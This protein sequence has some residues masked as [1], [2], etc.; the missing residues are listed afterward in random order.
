MRGRVLCVIIAAM[1]LLPLASASASPPVWVAVNGAYTV[2]MGNEHIMVVASDGTLWAWGGN[3]FGQLGDG[4]TNGSYAAIKIMD[5]VAAVSAGAYHSLAI[6]ND[7]TLWAWGSN[8]L[9]Q[10]GDGTREDSHVP[11]RVMSNVAFVSAYGTTSAAVRTD[12]SLW[13]WGRALYEAGIND[14]DTL[15][16]DFVAQE[17]FMNDIAAVSITNGSN[18]AVT[19]DGALLSF[20]WSMF[21]VADE[22]EQSDIDD[23]VDIVPEKI[24]DNVAAV[25][26]GLLHG[27]A[28]TADGNLW[29]WGDNSYGQLGDGT[30]IERPE[31]IRIMQNVVSVSAGAEYSM[32]VTADGR[33]WAWGWNA[34]G[35]LGDGTTE[36]SHVPVMV[37]DKIVAVSAGDAEVYSFAIREDGSL[38]V[39]GDT[40]YSQLGSGTTP[41]SHS[42]VR[43]MDD[44]MIPGLVLNPLAEPEPEPEPAE[45]EPVEEEVEVTLPPIEDV[46]IPPDSGGGFSI[47]NIWSLGAIMLIFGLWAVFKFV[48]KKDD[49]K[50][51]LVIVLCAVAVVVNVVTYFLY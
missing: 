35:Q 38:W 4:S 22:D 26:A 19:A 15:D 12:G 51:V 13:A 27:M 34:Y 11:V 16:E 33:L 8:T 17:S 44:V 49:L 2:S 29:V 42:L 23:P 18:Y 25:S 1:L 37:M 30:T 32:A 24:M 31:P 21:A 46:Y 3:T 47:L 5:N 41:D 10:L 20:D 39:W 48:L 14:S 40:R 36:E 6:K 9:G 7:G 50:L 45:K 43:I 28:I